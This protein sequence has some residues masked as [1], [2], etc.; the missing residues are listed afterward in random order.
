MITAFRSYAPETLDLVSQAVDGAAADL[1]FLRLAVEPCPRSSISVLITLL[2]R[3][4][5]T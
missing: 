4:R 5:G 3:R 1:G 2:W